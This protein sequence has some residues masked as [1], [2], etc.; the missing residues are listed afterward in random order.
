MKNIYTVI[1][2]S[3]V[4]TS[5]QSER[6]QVSND[7]IGIWT[8]QKCVAIQKDGNVNYPYVE[9]PVGQLFYDEKGNMMVEIMKPGI[10]KFASANLLQGTPEEILPAYYGFIAYYGTYKI[11]PDSNLVVHHLEACSFPNWINQDQKRYYEF[12]NGQ[13]ILRTPLIGSERYELIWQKVK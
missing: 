6:D 4:L 1:V 9:N 12:K 7:F 2:I 10:K 5:F 13:L 3:I 8:L 11:I